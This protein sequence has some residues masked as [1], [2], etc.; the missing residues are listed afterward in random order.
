M[1]IRCPSKRILIGK[2]DLDAAYRRVHANAQIAAICI[3]V[4]GTLAFLCMRLTFGNA[5]APAEYTTIIES[6]IELG[7]NLLA[8]T[9]WD[10]K[11]LRSPH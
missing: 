11:N 6:A 9:S 1:R 7:N 2:L 8:D 5:P 4:I 10:A 3:A